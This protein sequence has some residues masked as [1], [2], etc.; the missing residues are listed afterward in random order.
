MTLGIVNG[1]LASVALSVAIFVKVASVPVVSTLGRAPNTVDY[2]PLQDKN[3]YKVKRPDG[4][5][6]LRFEG[7]LFFANYSELEKN[8]SAHMVNRESTA[9]DGIVLWDSLVLDYCVSGLWCKD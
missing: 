6:V 8:V 9:D 7:P 4:I 1:L 2:R 3:N 5:L